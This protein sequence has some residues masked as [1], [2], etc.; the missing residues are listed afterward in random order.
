VGVISALLEHGADPL[1]VLPGQ[2]GDIFILNAMMDH[3]S[4]ELV[5]TL[6]KFEPRLCATWPVSSIGDG[7]GPLAHALLN[8]YE[9]P[10]FGVAVNGDRP[11]LEREN[12]VAGLLE[13]GSRWDVFTRGGALAAAAGSSAAAVLELL[14]EHG[15]K[16]EDMTAIERTAVQDTIDLMSRVYPDQH[17]RWAEWIQIMTPEPQAPTQRRRASP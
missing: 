6:A 11:H 14:G 13:L 5:A 17:A 8:R 10:V 16:V 9:I 7:A 2:D 15:C 4:P 1:A 3:A 12:A